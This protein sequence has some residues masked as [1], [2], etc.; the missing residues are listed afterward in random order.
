MGCCTSSLSPD[1]DD[2]R[3]PTPVV[4]PGMGAEPASPPRG[5]GLSRSHTSRSLEMSETLEGLEAELEVMQATSSAAAL[6]KK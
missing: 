2:E 6:E 1:D 4:P 3:R 5:P